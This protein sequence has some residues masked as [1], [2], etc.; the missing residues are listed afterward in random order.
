MVM[1]ATKGSIDRRVARTRATLHQT[2]MSL[3]LKQGYEAITIKDICDAANVGRSTFYAHYTSKD[4]LMRS[5]IE[6]LRRVLLDRQRDALATP[7]DIRHRSLGFSL[8]LFE[9]ARDHIDL[10][11]GLVG[12]GAVALGIIRQILSDV[13]RDELAAT[14]GKSSAEAI[15]REF[16]VQYIVGAY[17]AVLTWWLDRG[18]KPPPTEVDRMFRRLATDGILPHLAEG[19]S[20]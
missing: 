4:D 20:H 11:R 15:P 2:L 13:V 9:H 3:I 6:N 18:A 10:H 5:G 1:K 8:T 7:G 19:G 17:M 12:G 14:A 16:V